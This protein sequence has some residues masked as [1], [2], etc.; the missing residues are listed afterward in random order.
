[1]QQEAQP[2]VEFLGLKFNPA[3][4]IMTVLIMVAVALFARF[5]VSRLDMRR[6]RGTQNVLEWLVE[7]IRG[8]AGS[9]MPEETAQRY[10][11]L[12]LTL[13]MFIFV[14]NMSDLPISIIQEFPHGSAFLH[15]PPGKEVNWWV[16]PTANLNV[17]MAMSGMVI[18][19]SHWIGLRKPKTYFKHYFEPFVFFLPINI[20]EEGSK[21]LTLG[22]RLFGNIFAGEVL[23]AV[24]LGMPKFLGVVHVGVIP[25]VVWLGYSVFVGTIQAFVFT[26]LTLTYISQKLFLEEHH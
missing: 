14:S 16:A 23:I 26:V 25:L 6:P 15:I 24:L 4:M 20:L 7:F 9:S 10:V 13:I 11:P 1:L 3:V 8:L 2:Y 19:L 5:A 17:T 12:A 18:V 21:F 22:L